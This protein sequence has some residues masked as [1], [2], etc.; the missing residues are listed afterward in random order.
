MNSPYLHTL[1]NGPSF[2][3]IPIEGGSFSMGGD[4]GG[5]DDSLPEHPVQLEDYYLSRKLVSQALYEAVM[6]T[7]P[8]AFVHP[9]RPVE[10][11]SWYN[12]VAFCNELS[13][14]MGLEPYYT[15]D[16]DQEDPNN[17]NS[18]DDMKWLVKINPGSK[19]YRLPTEAEWE[20][21]AR[22]GKYARDLIY[23]GSPNLKE[24]AW[25][26]KN[27][28]GI[29][30]PVGLRRPNVLGLYDLSGNLREWCW[31]W[32]GGKYYQVCADQ[33]TVPNPTGPEKGSSRVVRGGAWYSVNGSYLRVA[34]RS[35]INPFS[36]SYLRGFRVSRYR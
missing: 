6:G 32:Y 15:I 2:E 28:Q 9:Q 19:G 16:K 7:N 26:G 22:G 10:K 34:F 35:Y 29:S 25:F 30:Q 31:D 20:Y 5:Y 12:A 24:V 21:A 36:D 27:S 33:G 17:T 11:V 14:K 8:S 18:S 3:M 13:Q 4:S 1:P 23:S